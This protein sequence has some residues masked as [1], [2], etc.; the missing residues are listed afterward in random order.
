MIIYLFSFSLFAIQC[1]DFFLFECS[2]KAVGGDAAFVE[3]SVPPQATHYHVEES[4]RTSEEMSA[5]QLVEELGAAADRQAELVT[6]LKAR[7]FGESSSL[8]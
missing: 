6:H 1:L 7:Y 5:Q 4:L 8:S 3:G 2:D